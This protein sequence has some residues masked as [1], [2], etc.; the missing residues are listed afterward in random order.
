[1]ALEVFKLVGS[2]FVDTDKAND[3]LQKVDKNANK[4]AEGFANAGKV[5]AGVGVA[6][7]TAVVGASTA[8]V[9]MANDTAEMAD[10]IDKASIRMGISAEQYQ[11]L[12]YAAGQC[13]V[14][15]S[16][17][18]QAAKKLEGTDMS[19]DDAINSIMELG[20]AEE[21]SAA[22]VD[23][24][25][26]K[27][28]YSLS[29]ILEQSGGDFDALKER[30]HDLGL[31]MSDTAVKTGVQYGDLKSDL[32][33]TANSLKTSI[34]SAVMPIL[35]KL[36][37]KL[38]EFMPTIQGL[39]DKIGPFA[40]EFIEELLPPLL[41]IAEDI[42]PM[43]ID[44]VSEILPSLSSIVKELLP[45]ILN[46]LRELLPV[47]VQVVSSILPVLVEI[48]QKLTPILSQV[49]EFLSPI[50]EL[51]LQLITPL[52]NLVMHILS[53]IFDL[54][55]ALLT[56]LL[57]LLTNILT[58]IFGIIEVLLAPLTAILDV[59]LTPMNKVLEVLLVPLT[60]LLDMILPPLLTLVETFL[61]WASPYLT[62]FFEFIADAV[63][64][65]GDWFG[66]NGLTK[67][68]QNFG[69]FFESLWDGIVE[70]FKTAINFIIKGINNLIEGLNK[71]DPPEWLTKATGFT[72]VNIKT[73]PLLADGG[74]IE[75]AGRVIVGERGPEMLDLPKG[76]RVSPL[77][78]SEFDF[79]RLTEAFVTALRIVAPE[80]SSNVVVEGDRDNLVRVLVS[81]DKQKRK[82][83]GK[84]LFEI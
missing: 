56:P 4:V 8:I 60:E 24:F 30:A 81:E 50:L 11:E 69:D 53:P 15:M 25:G 49:M 44:A 63:E 7:G 57:E 59:I 42:L 45:V 36:S 14:E 70:A 12:A 83:S 2:V 5:A 75:E 19:F 32:E 52:L 61:E 10:T 38:I 37:E 29:P 51:V 21:R 55:M 58:P 40:A 80:L 17:M 35:V 18:E 68:F 31:V 78:N 67:V 34:G 65:M 48:I 26:E 46:L 9:G 22:A 20:T 73:I 1:M 74:N 13:G 27:V 76:A 79:D 39:I 41:E 62:T 3:S 23:L 64:N 66:S 72:G 71:V 82:Q 16:T 54:I 47:V 6:I 43:A 33:K 28:A 77:D 84:G